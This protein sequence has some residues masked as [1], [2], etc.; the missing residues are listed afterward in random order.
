LTDY[1]PIISNKDPG[2]SVT[3]CIFKVQNPYQMPVQTTRLLVLLLLALLVAC[4]YTQ[5]IR[6][7]RTAFDRKQY[8]VATGL[9]QKEYNKAKT[10]LEKGK[11]A[12]LMGL[13]YKELGKSDVSIQW[14]RTAYDNQAGL[15]A[16]R[17]Y[18][19][20]LKQAE[21]YEEAMGAFKDLGIEI[22]S[23]YEYRREIIA[24]ENALGWKQ[25]KTKEYV[26]E[27]LPF[28]SPVAD[29]SPALFKDNQLVFTSDRKNSTGDDTYNWTG[30]AF[31]DL[32]IADASGSVVGGFSET[33][34]TPDNEGTAVFSE[35]RGEVYFTRCYGG[36]KEDANCKIMLSE[37]KNGVWLPARPLDLLDGENLNY[38]QPAIS[39]DGKKLY[40]SCNHPEGWGGYDIWVSTRTAD[41]WGKG[42][43]MSRS[44]NTPGNEK[45]PSID[46]DTLY[47]SSDHHIGMGGLDI[48]RTNKMNNGSW[49]PAYNLKPPVNS[50]GDDF[51]FII[52]RNANLDK[53]VLLTGYFSS[54]RPGGAG[55]DDIYRFEKRIPPPAPPVDSTK[56]KALVYKMILDGYVLEKI[57]EQPG[58]PNSRVLGRKPLPGSKV[59]I[60]FGKEKKTVTVG[61]DGLFTLELAENADYNFLASAEN[62]LNNKAAFSTK[63]IGKDP[64]NPVQRFEV[65]IVLDRIYL[66]QEIR[67]ENIY[68]DYDKWDIR[69]DAKPTLDALTETLRLNPQIRIQLSSHTDCR[70]ADSYNE[71]LSQRRAQSAVDYLITKGIDATRLSARGYGESQL[72]VNCLCARC[73]EEEHQANRRTTFKILE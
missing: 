62:Y 5:K 47:F 52:D 55:S 19:F 36:K 60:R 30:N 27:P 63:G 45:F 38:G 31:S 10:R 9:L 33:L 7:G 21:Q 20:A 26:V 14:F 40:F 18:A 69:N 12:Y 50:G 67:L 8:S 72:E 32:Y 2:G 46:G 44:I 16:L 70:G 41:G 24:C 58:N 1:T 64:E 25:T 73:T 71:Q 42:E 37:I 39:A 23:P 28:N 13:S 68:Y 53:D 59:E 43:L 34:N 35:N 17:E 65:E 49:A 61:E 4:N 57:F 3:N 29:Y 54:N 48:F 6:D 15:D 11:I 22:G 66:E 51:G 56:L